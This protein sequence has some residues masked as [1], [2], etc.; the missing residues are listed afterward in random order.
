MVRPT[1]DRILLLP[2]D[3]PPLRE[4]PPSPAEVGW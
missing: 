4:L 3:A 1:L 2:V